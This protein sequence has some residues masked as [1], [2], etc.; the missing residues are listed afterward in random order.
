MS[1]DVQDAE[2]ASRNSPRAWWPLQARLPALPIIDDG[3]FAAADRLNCY[4]LVL[5]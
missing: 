5:A 2:D 4:Q 3:C 1:A